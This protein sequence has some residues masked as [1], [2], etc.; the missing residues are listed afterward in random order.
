M[1][2]DT[3][4]NETGKFEAELK[5][6]GEPKN[7]TVSRDHDKTHTLPRHTTNNKTPKNKAKL[8]DAKLLRN[9]PKIKILPRTTTKSDAVP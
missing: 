1:H 4:T 2:M 8:L 3:T 6:N 5:T 9:L 7:K